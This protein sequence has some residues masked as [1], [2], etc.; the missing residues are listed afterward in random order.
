MQHLQSD[1]R[2]ST[3]KCRF[4]P[5]KAMKLWPDKSIC[6]S[7][8]VANESKIMRLCPCLHEICIFN[9]TSYET[10]DGMKSGSPQVPIG[11]YECL[12]QKA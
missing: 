12:H 5:L 1:P 10:F 11:A 4:E 2:P 3:P 9:V 6:N 8:L 7:I